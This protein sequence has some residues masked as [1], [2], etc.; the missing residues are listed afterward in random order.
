VISSNLDSG[1]DIF[2]QWHLSLQPF[3]C[4]SHV[5]ISY[6]N[7]GWTVQYL[8]RSTFDIG[9]S[10]G[11]ERVELPQ[12]PQ[13]LGWP[14]S[15]P[16]WEVPGWERWCAQERLLLALWS[17][18]VMSVSS[19]GLLSSDATYTKHHSQV[20][21]ISVLYL[22]GTRFKFQP[23]G[24]LFWGFQNFLKLSGYAVLLPGPLVFALRFYANCYSLNITFNKLHWAESLKT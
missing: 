21:N 14:T 24:W 23:G 19:T 2:S 20:H 1:S 17:R 5:D 18:S 10:H 6:H 9:H 15:I 3:M 8:I 12:W 16:P 22:W 7:Q 4:D 11:L 13:L